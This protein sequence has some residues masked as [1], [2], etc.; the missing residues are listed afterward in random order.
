MPPP[1]NI[2]PTLTL[3]GGLSLSVS[4]DPKFIDRKDDYYADKPLKPHLQVRLNEFTLALGSE[5]T[6]EFDR[7]RLP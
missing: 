5:L 4:M 3:I 6:E 7:S 2:T 1:S